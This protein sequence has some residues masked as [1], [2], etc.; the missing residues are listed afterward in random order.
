MKKLISILLSFILLFALSACS[1]NNG[2][3]SSSSNAEAP[4]SS[5]SPLPD[6]EACTVVSENGNWEIT[7]DRTFEVEEGRNSGFSFDI[8]YIGDEEYNK[9]TTYAQIE[10]TVED[11]TIARAYTDIYWANLVSIAAVAKAGAETAATLKVSPEM[12]DFHDG[13][14]EAIEIP[15]T[16]R[17]VEPK[18]IDKT[19]TEQSTKNGK[20]TMSLEKNEVTLDVGETVNL[21]YEISAPGFDINTEAILWA[22]YHCCL[23]EYPE[24]TNLI[25]VTKKSTDAIGAE[26]N[27]YLEI[28]GKEVGDTML[29]ITLGTNDGCIT[30]AVEVHV[31]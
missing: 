25:E 24:N 6:S 15:F 19:P 27:Y 18:K 31:V 12:P 13:F 22:D 30:F 14:D 16:I 11:K 20:W 1:D 29:Y 5:E 17:I 21:S 26:Y 7:Y 8:K 23:W 4:S 9:K 10:A 3:E 28:E 2:G